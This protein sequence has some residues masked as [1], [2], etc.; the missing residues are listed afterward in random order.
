MTKD[1]FIKC[2]IPEEIETALADF[3]HRTGLSRADAI[4]EGLTRGLGGAAS[5]S[6]PQVVVRPQ[7]ADK[8]LQA[9]IDLREPISKL[10]QAAKQLRTLI[11]QHGAD[12]ISSRHQIVSVIQN[13]YAEYVKIRKIKETLLGLTAQDVD[14]LV[15]MKQLL[16]EQDSSKPIGRILIKLLHHL[17]F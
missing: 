17:G 14:D 3:Q 5:S 9:I 13:A 11:N 15:G 10:H 6:I 7:W 12:A 1:F 16:V 4:R 2:R 8:D